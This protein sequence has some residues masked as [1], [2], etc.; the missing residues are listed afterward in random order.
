MGK[1]STRKR[2][3][4]WYYSF[5][6]SE[7]GGKRKRVEKGG[8]SS[9]KE[10]MEAGVIAQASFL[11]G[12]IALTSDKVRLSAFLDEWLKMKKGDLRKNTLVSYEIARN[13]ILLY[14]NDQFIFILHTFKAFLNDF[15][16]AKTALSL[17]L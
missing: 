3:Q 14:M 8:F 4:K 1:I 11:K 15:K 13:R 9:Q 10:A 6:A 16:N 5:E 17:E 2:G 12:N 7:K